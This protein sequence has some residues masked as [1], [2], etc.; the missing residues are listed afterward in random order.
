MNDISEPGYLQGKIHRKRQYT[1]LVCYQYMSCM[2]D[3]LNLPHN[4]LYRQHNNH[5]VLVVVLVVLLLVLLLVLRLL[6]RLLLL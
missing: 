5:L 1:L 4:K 2:M 3:V 6:L